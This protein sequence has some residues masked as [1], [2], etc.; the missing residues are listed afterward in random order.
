MW[1]YNL[2]RTSLSILYPDDMTTITT[3]NKGIIAQFDE[4][5]KREWDDIEQDAFLEAMA[6]YMEGAARER[7][8]DTKKHTPTKPYQTGIRS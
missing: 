8:H 1:D 2:S 4:N 6:I 7:K 5:Y 3:T